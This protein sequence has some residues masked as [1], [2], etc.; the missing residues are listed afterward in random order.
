MS[1]IKKIFRVRDHFIADMWSEEQ[2]LYKHRPNFC[3][4]VCE[5]WLL[6]VCERVVKLFKDLSFQLAHHV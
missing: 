1:S 4:F 5:M 6:H 2:E 3:S